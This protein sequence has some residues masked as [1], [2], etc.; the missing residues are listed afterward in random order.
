MHAAQ[1][2]HE[3]DSVLTRLGVITVA[4]FDA[5]AALGVLVERLAEARVARGLSQRALGARLGMAE[6]VVGKWELRV[7]RP[8]VASLIRW[9]FELG[10][11]LVVV[12]LDGCVPAVTV[13]PRTRE[14][15]ERFVARR[16]AL[17]LRRERWERRW[18]QEQVGQRLGGSEWTVR[19]WETTRRDPRVT[20]LLAWADTLDCR[21]QLTTTT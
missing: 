2:K 3:F 1:V 11:D 15:V 14:P 17:T 6:I 16:M 18:S 12:R 20:H 19:M 8:S 10:F 9:V 7:E 21:V 5:D 4:G 13:I